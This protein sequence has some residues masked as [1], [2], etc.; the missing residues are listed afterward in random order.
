ME[1]LLP[2]ARAV[3]GTGVDIRVMSEALPALSTGS[4]VAEGAV[5]TLATFLF[6]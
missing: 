5:W 4:P 1:K 3:L 6:L 2:G